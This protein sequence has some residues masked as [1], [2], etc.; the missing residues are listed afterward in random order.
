VSNCIARSGSKPIWLSM[1]LILCGIKRPK[2]VDSA[3][4]KGFAILDPKPATKNGSRAL[5]DPVVRRPSNSSFGRLYGDDLPDNVVFL[6]EKLL[7]AAAGVCDRECKVVPFLSGHVPW[8]NTMSGTIWLQLNFPSAL[9]FA[10]VMVHPGRHMTCCTRICP[11]STPPPTHTHTRT[12]TRTRARA[13]ARARARTRTRTCACAPRLPTADACRQACIPVGVMGTC[14]PAWASGFGTHAVRLC[15]RMRRVR[16]C[17][18]GWVCEC[19]AGVPYL[20]CVLCMSCVALLWVRERKRVA[21][22]RV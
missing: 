10:T 11:T 19:G 15:G 3:L 18:Y 14:L 20:L 2:Y 12:R 1:L 16:V 22:M 8:C 21:Y 17:V 9:R 4:Q 7:A 13:R 6:L 5:F